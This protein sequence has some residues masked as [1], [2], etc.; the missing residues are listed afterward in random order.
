MTDY[1]VAID[2]GTSH[3]TGIVGEKRTDG[4]FSIIA[5]ETVDPAS[6]IRRGII[7]NRDNTATH[8]NG[9]LR[10]LES[11]LKGNFIDK[12]YIGVGGQSLHTVDH[13]EVK[14]IADGAAVTKEDID[15]LKDQCGKYKPDLLD[16]LDVAPAVY[17]VDGRR[18]TN[19]VGVPCKRFEAR[20]KLV[21]GRSSIRRDIAKSIKELAGKE[22]AGIIVS[23]LALADAMLSREEKELGCA[24]VDFGAGV[25]TVSVYKDGDLLHMSVIPLGGNLITRDI[26]SLQ[27]TEAE[28]ENLKKEYGSAVLH[29]EDE[30][31]TIR[32]D[33]EGADREIEVNDLNAIIEGRAKEIVEN[34]YAR[35]SEVTELKSLGSGIVLAGCA[36]ELKDL[37]ELIKEKSKVKVR[38]SAIRG[39]LVQG[40]GDMLG[41]PLYMLVISLM[42]K[43]TEPC[44]SRPFTEHGN[45]TTSTG[46]ETDLSGADNA[47]TQETG[48]MGSRGVLGGSDS[49]KRPK[50]KGFKEKIRDLF[51]ED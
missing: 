11:H 26:V 36:A 40:S 50:G 12:V 10:R 33:M 27:L 24:L 45:D 20:Y 47:G 3:I 4:T 25:T 49:V 42:L 5:C 48:D 51:G 6:C 39:G 15:A 21:V 23:P 8:V 34:V 16:V 41:N 18:D 9:L 14:D 1:I 7:Y 46:P 37:P 22:I 32:V 13:T 35:I 2:L 29:K 38:P 30:G 17:Y 43:G 19:P 31:E 28:A 44:V